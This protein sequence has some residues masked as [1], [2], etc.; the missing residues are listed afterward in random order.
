MNATAPVVN[1]RQDGTTWHALVPR[2]L[3]EHGSRRVAEVGVW[4]GEL[5]RKILAH[6]PAVTSLVLVD[7][8]TP[9]YGNDPTHGMM[10]FG[11]GTDQAE[12]DDAYLRVCKQFGN[13]PRVTIRK[14]FSVEVAPLMP[15]RYFD[16]VLI[17]ALHTYHACKEDILAW[18]PK[19]RVGGVL[20]GDDHSAWF[21][22]VQ[23]AVE[24]IFGT[25]HQVLDQTYWKII[26]EDDH[27]RIARSA[28]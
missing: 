12:M 18:L 7:S 1:A 23:V 3:A 14:G 20:I 22:G 26:G 15:D 9:I 2:L 6:C 17:D 28:H 21:P 11:P 8:W 16:A 10:V 19:V 5:S 24:E 4:R 27:A 25:S 13:E